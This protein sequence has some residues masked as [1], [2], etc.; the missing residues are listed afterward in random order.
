MNRI[1]KSI[2][3]SF[4]IQKEQSLSQLVI[5]TSIPKGT[6]KKYL[7]VLVEKG[8]LNAVGNGR[9][10]Y[11][12]YISL[13]QTNQIAV[14]KS[15]VL[16]GF[17]GHE[18]GQYLFEYDTQ[19]KGKKLDGLSHDESTSATLFPIFENLIPE[20]DRRDTYSGENKNLAEILL[21]LQNTHGDFDFVPAD[22]LYAYKSDY[23][24]RKNWM[25]VKEKILEYQEYV[26]ILDF[27]IDIEEEIDPTL[28]WVARFLQVCKSKS[29]T[30]H[31]ASLHWL[32]AVSA[33]FHLLL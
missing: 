6:I 32:Q 25:L 22:K 20:S 30:S 2:I 5:H 15:A 33:S 11:Y 14:F 3:E 23:T 16:V 12:Q 13:Q 24:K 9:G 21:E 17:L 31:S 19:Y 8:M 28:L 26:N 7:S 18:I 10:R 29:C 27:K 4:F 1:E